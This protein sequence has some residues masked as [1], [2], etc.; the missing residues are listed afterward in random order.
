MSKSYIHDSQ[1]LSAGLSRVEMIEIFYCFS[2]KLIIRKA[3]KLTDFNC[4]KIDNRE[5]LSHFYLNKGLKRR[6]VDCASKMSIRRF[7]SL[8]LKGVTG[9]VW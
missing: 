7:L 2:L 9:N 5:Y 1:P 8:S 6:D 3:R 4:F